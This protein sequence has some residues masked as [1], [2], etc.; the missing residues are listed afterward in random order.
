MSGAADS[1]PAGA[2]TIHNPM[3]TQTNAGVINIRSE[4]EEEQKRGVAEIPSSST[5][6]DSMMAQLL[7]GMR[8]MKQVLDR[9]EDKLTKQQQRIDE[10]EADKDSPGRVAAAEALPTPI[11]S[12]RYPTTAARN[13]A[14]N[15]LSFGVPTQ[16]F[17]DS[18]PST[19]MQRSNPPAVSSTRASPTE[20]EMDAEDKRVK[21]VLGVMKG[22]VDPF[23]G[24]ATHDKSTTVM[25][26]VEKLETSMNDIM[27]HRPQYR[28]LVVRAFLKE[29]AMRWMNNT[30]NDLT[31][32][33]PRQG[34]NLDTDPIQ[35]DTDLRSL[36]IKKYIGRDTVT[37]WLSKLS[38][39]KLGT[40]RTPTPIELDSQFDAIA[41]HV[42][43][44]RDLDDT[45]VDLL[46]TQYYSK[47]VY[48]YS[49][50]MWN[51]IARS[52]KPKTLIEW[53]ERLSEQ[54]VTEEEAKAMQR[55]ASNSTYRSGYRGRGGYNKYRER[56]TADEKSTSA[57]AASMAATDGA[58]AEGQQAEESEEEQLNAASSSRGGRGG[59]RGGRGRGGNRQQAKPWT[60]EMRKRYFDGLCLTCG[61][62]DHMA[63]SC[64]KD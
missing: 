4:Q 34:R 24:D 5:I 50:V 20:A 41:R 17:E 8:Q 57:S 56:S 11:P 2:A 13:G 9:T 46:L 30:I 29:G 43:P 14:H 23:Y 47:I 38:C 31:T 10:L 55:S 26:F 15:R 27:R 42:Y 12:S 18:P 21:E 35:W 37:L 62:A 49:E 63:R 25:D 53:K 16:S 6:A 1:P 33:A 40:T 64:P 48:Q 59:G 45:S 32:K 61:A 19:P 54:F 39:L 58:G 60:D 36:F 52:N 28:L 44:T 51:N 22:I 7:E 3:Q